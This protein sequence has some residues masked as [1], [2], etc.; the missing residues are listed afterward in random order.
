MSKRRHIAIIVTGSILSGA[1]MA[2]AGFE[3]VQDR[4]NQPLAVAILLLCV[5]QLLV[6]LRSRGKAQQTRA[7][8]AEAPRAAGRLNA[9]A[10]R[11]TAGQAAASDTPPTPEMPDPALP[12]TGVELLDR[13]RLDLYLEPIVAIEDSRTVYYRSS[14]ALTRD[15]G[16]HVGAYLLNLTAE[17]GGFAPALDLAAFRRV[18]PVVRHLRARNR[19]P[20]VFCPLAPESFAQ[21]SF[22]DELVAFLRA[23]Q[24]AAGAMVIELSQ[25]ALGALSPAGMEGLAYLA[26]LG[27]TF[28]LSEAQVEGPDLG[29]LVQ[30]GFQFLDLNVAALASVHGWDAFDETGAVCRLGRRAEEAGLT[31]IAANLVRAEELERVRPF[32]RLARGALFSPPRV[33]RRDLAEA[34]PQAAAA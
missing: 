21:R 20:G 7:P 22:L 29:T 34:A 5:G 6:L 14:V 11:A 18:C 16:S 28:S 2:V 9:G 25:P 23:N 17:R 12:D 31:V 1:A 19:R 13:G 32:V 10:I 30:L 15:D 8:E 4:G 3:I 33:V 27:A 24:D 26:E